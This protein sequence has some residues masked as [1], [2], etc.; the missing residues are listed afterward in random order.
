ME[1]MLTKDE[2]E[3]Y[4]YIIRNTLCG[5]NYRSLSNVIFFNNDAVYEFLCEIPLAGIPGSVGDALN[6]VSAFI[7]INIGNASIDF[8]MSAGSP[9]QLKALEAELIKRNKLEFLQLITQISTGSDW[10]SLVN[11]CETIR[12][13]RENEAKAAM[14]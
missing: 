13:F 10:L 7:P 9:E 14:I 1:K 6:T 2:L 5:Y 11:L 3:K 4:L 12:L 8:F